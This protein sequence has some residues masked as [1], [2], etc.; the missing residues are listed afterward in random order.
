MMDNIKEPMIISFLIVF[1]IAF[2]FI[3]IPILNKSSQTTKEVF[4]ENENGNNEIANAKIVSK[5]IYSPVGSIE[6][7]NF[8][9]FEKQNGERIELAIKDDEQYKMMLEGD[10]GTLT[11]LGKRFISFIR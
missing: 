10:F 2:I 5:K 3:V 7:F 8:V 9:I 4:G 11:H 6:R 1:A